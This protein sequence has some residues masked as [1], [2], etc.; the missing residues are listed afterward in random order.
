M[1]TPPTK[2]AAGHLTWSGLIVRAVFAGFV[3]STTWFA[4]GDDFL[5]RT[6]NGVRLD[7]GSFLA[8]PIVA[9]LALSLKRRTSNPVVGHLVAYARTSLFFFSG[10]MGC[11]WLFDRTATSGEFWGLAV[12]A[13]MVAA[14]VLSTLAALLS[15]I[16]RRWEHRR[17]CA[18]PVARTVVAPFILFYAAVFTYLAVSQFLD[19][20]RSALV[21]LMRSASAPTGEFQANAVIILIAPSVFGVY[22]LSLRELLTRLQD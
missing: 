6:P 1:K 2:V 15:L 20:H 12:V 21:N 16:L 14:I 4:L 11:F 3:L 18:L 22:W 7:E 8:V 13:S 10:W 19:G 5:I 17:G 9:L